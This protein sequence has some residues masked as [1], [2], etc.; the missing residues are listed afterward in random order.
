M[1]NEYTNVLV[2]GGGI[3]G[4]TTAIE[5]AEIG[6]EVLL[7]EKEPY[8]GGRVARMNQYF[9]K[10]CPPTCGLEINFRRIKQNPNV[11]LFTSTTVEQISG[12][13]GN[14]EIKLK[15]EPMFVNDKCTACGDCAEVC[16][17]EIPNDF[18]YGLGKTK[19]FNIP[20]LMA[21]PARYSVDRKALNDEQYKKCMEACKYGAIEENPEAKTFTVKAGSVVVAT[22]WSPYDATRIEN[23]GFGEY[24][25][26]LT[27][28]I[29]E[30]LAS[31]NGPTGGK[32]LRPSD[33]KQVKKIAFVQCA[34]SR[35]E[36][37][38][39]F[40]SGVCCLASLKHSMYVREKDPEAT[41]EIFY[42]DIRT[43]GRLEDFLGRVQS[44][45]NIT[46]T[47]GK[48]ARIEQTAEQDLLVTVE[49]VLG[50][51]KQ[52]KRFDMVVLATGMKPNGL[53]VQLPS[54]VQFDEY[55]FLAET[56]PS[57]GIFVA[58][59][60]KHPVDVSSSVQDSTAAAAKVLSIGK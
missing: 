47:K 20:H 60:A 54:G 52:K 7:V 35:D 57:S 44:E 25:N 6:R 51:E 23:L 21:Y 14:Y 1:P 2:I 43:L 55:G 16:D 24:P 34:G 33:S 56:D 49:D 37:H 5:A 9:P 8:L 48:V 18:N 30:R 27:N 3:S 58:G 15:T 46:L 19:A 11:R 53:D 32:L 31:L 22:G 50:G 26:V 10:L 38:L 17:V 41:S 12:S 13:A 45:E 36:N 42:I 59:C 4:M 40:C 29:F 39:H 28:V